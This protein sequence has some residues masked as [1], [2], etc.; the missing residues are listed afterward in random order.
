METK[1][2]DNQEEKLGDLLQDELGAATNT[3]I[4]VAFA[5]ESGLKIL[6]RGIRRALSNGASVEVLV[7]LDFST[8]DPQALWHM[9]QWRKDNALFSFFCLPPGGP[10]IYHP[11]MYLMLKRENATIVVGSSNLTDA[12]LMKNAEANLLIRDSADSELISDA[13]ESYLRLKFDKRFIPDEDFLAAYEEATRTSKKANKAAR[14]TGNLAALEK[15]LREKAA[16]LAGPI[17]TEKEL[18]GWMKLVYEALPDGEFTNAD[19]YQHEQ[20]F[21]KEY[22]DNQ[23]VL[24]KI[25]QQLQNLEKIG[26][27]EHISSGNWRKL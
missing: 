6:D 21:H 14:A 27:L 13:I 9:D 22:P 18:A 4:A 23:H 12:G 8:T 19:I 17:A 15:S 26:L 3:R 11:K 20:E 16:A 25:R 2:V 10:G 7:G 1:F 5:S 24:D